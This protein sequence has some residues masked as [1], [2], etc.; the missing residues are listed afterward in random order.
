MIGP[1][2][3]REGETVTADGTRIW[4]K[5]YPATMTLSREA[6][7]ERLRRERVVAVVFDSEIE[8]ARIDAMLAE[9]TTP[10]TESGVS[11]P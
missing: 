6:A 3:I 11:S 7:I 8:V 4:W 5:E 10:D 9:L 1:D 2:P